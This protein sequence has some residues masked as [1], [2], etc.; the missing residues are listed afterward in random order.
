MTELVAAGAAGLA[1]PRALRPLAWLSLAAALALLGAAGFA[2]LGIW[3]LQRLG[4]KLALIERVEARVHAP[5]VAAPGP[6]RW[7]A[8]AGEEYR[9]V[10][11]TGRF[12]SERETLVQAVT[13]RGGGFW[14]LT[15]LRDAAGFTVLVNRGFVPPERRDPASRA[16]T[17]AGE[18]SV[19]GLLR[20]TEPKGGFLR[21]ND[22]DGGR[23]YSRDV[24]AIAQARALGGAVAPYFVDA[25]DTPNAGGFPIG[26]LTV[27]RFANNHLVYALTWFG[28]ALMLCAATVFVLR[29]E[30]RVRRMMERDH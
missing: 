16:S 6:D 27:L 18:V 13:E 10:R 19:T 29:G 24:G 23:W 30:Y 22:P 2:G 12:L 11:L 3:Q 21:A 5:A 8:V 26:G 25:D 15:P 9:R 7:A 14:V 17:P 28:L 4:W 1:P 20:L